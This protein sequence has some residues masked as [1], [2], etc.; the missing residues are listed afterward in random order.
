MSAESFGELVRAAAREQLA[1]LARLDRATPPS[2]QLAHR[3]DLDHALHQRQTAR[4]A[5]TREATRVR[6]AR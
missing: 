6:T 3:L 4:Y 5:L 1:L 2:L